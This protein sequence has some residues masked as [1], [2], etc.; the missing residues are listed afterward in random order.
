MQPSLEA[1]L[2]ALVAIPSISNNSAACHEILEYVRDQIAPFGLHIEGDFNRSSPWMI[3]TTRATKQPDI[4]LAT[5]LDVVPAPLELFAMEK[6][7]GKLYGRGVFDMKLA[8]ACYIEFIK[9]NA[10]LLPSLNIGF[11][12]TTDEEV[13]SA[14][15]LDILNA[16][17]HPGIVFLPDGGDNWHI[18]RRAKGIYGIELIAHGQAAHGS[19]PWEGKNAIHTLMQALTEL[20]T[21]YPLEEPAEATLNVNMIDGGEAINQIADSASAYIDFRSFKKQELAEYQEV[22]A[23]LAKKYSLTV[24][25]I[26]TGEPVAFDPSTPKAHHFITTLEEITGEKAAFCDSY[27]ASDARFFT[28][29][30]IP[31]II[32]EPTGG[33]RHSADEWLL[34]ADLEKY[35]QLIERWLIK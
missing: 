10:A 31:S 26:N 34:A 29:Y 33:G 9:A 3:A 7:N 35:Y 23:D 24:R 21:V 8:A 22:L 17:W 19:R 2:A 1:T 28:R 30:N 27:G 25:P 20:R 6:Q 5:H 18:E 16:G 32:I 15:M 12:F 4:L 14:C 11:L 13:D